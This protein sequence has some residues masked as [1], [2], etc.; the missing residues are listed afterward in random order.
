[1]NNQ[2]ASIIVLVGLLI[3]GCKEENAA[4]VAAPIAPPR[5]NLIQSQG[6][7]ASKSGRTISL[8]CSDGSSTSFNAAP[9]IHVKDGLGVDKPNLIFAG[10]HDGFYSLYN[11]TSGNTLIYTTGGGLSSITEVYFENANCTGQAYAWVQS[12]PSLKG[13]VLLNDNA[14]PGGAQAL[15]ITGLYASASVLS[16]YQN[17]SCTAAGP[18]LSTATTF[19]PG[20]SSLEAIALSASDPQSITLPIELVTD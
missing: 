15:K 2:K 18:G 11:S 10:H 16:H 12:G 1:M 17:G 14:W 13:R 6:C 20:I 5:Q 7:T 8:N 9:S 3:S 4:E 19:S